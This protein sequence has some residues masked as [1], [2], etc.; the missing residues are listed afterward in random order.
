MAKKDLQTQVFLFVTHQPVE[1]LLRI[2][3]RA[4]SVRRIDNISAAQ[5]KPAIKPS[6]SPLGRWP[7]RTNRSV[8]SRS[9]PA[10]RCP[11]RRTRSGSSSTRES[12]YPRNAPAQFS[13]GWH[14]KN[15]YKAG[16]DNQHRRNLDH[17]LVRR[18]DRGDRFAQEQDQARRERR[19][20]QCCAE[21]DLRRETCLARDCRPQCLTDP[22]GHRHAQRSRES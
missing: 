18:V 22:H 21:P 17:G 6:H 20:Y 4:L 9:R 12:W 16:I 3:R 15:W 1:R 10:G 5:L 11:N 8:P 14:R 2:R 7:D 13:P 19:E